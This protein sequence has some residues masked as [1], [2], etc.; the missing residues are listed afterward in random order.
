MSSISYFKNTKFIKGTLEKIEDTQKVF[1]FYIGVDYE[2]G[3][4]G[5]HFLMQYITELH[6]PGQGQNPSADF[7]SIL[8]S[9]SIY[10]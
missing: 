8:S 1:S 6:F 7:D 3:V 5:L 10:A 4:N 2:W 9:L